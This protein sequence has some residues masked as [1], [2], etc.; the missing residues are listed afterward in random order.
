MSEYV[1][2]ATY[3]M[4]CVTVRCMKLRN[5]ISDKESLIFYQINIKYALIS[6]RIKN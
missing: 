5:F 1:N 2:N 6:S 4:G 3:I